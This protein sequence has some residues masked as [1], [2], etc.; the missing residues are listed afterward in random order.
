MS[1]VTQ[2]IR[3]ICNVSVSSETLTE[4]G[5]GLG[6]AQRFPSSRVY[7]NDKLLRTFQMAKWNN[8]PDSKTFVDLPL[9]EDPE[10]VV[11]R[12]KKLG[13]NPSELQAKSFLKQ[14]FYS[15]PRD[16]KQIA[17]YTPRDYKHDPPLFATRAF[18]K[19]HNLVLFAHAIKKRWPKLCREFIGINGSNSPQAPWQS[20]PRSSLIALPHPF[21]VPGGRFREMYYWDTLWIVQGL[22]ASQMLL[23]AMGVA[24]NCM[25]L[26]K[27][28]GFV[29]NGN[30][31]YYLNRSQ[32]PI[33]ASAV[34]EI[35]NALETKG[36]KILWA[37]ESLPA[38]ELEIESF[39]LH[40]SAGNEYKPLCRYSVSTE[41]PRP[42]S[43]RE[44][45]HTAERTKALRPRSKRSLVYKEIASAAESGWDFTSRFFRDYSE[46]L[47][48]VRT[49]KIIPVCLNSLL[50][51]SEQII[52]QM[53]EYLRDHLDVAENSDYYI[54]QAKMFAFKSKK[55][56]QMMN[57]VLWNDLHSTWMDY[58]MELEKHTETISIAGIMPLMGKC[59]DAWDD[60]MAENY[61]SALMKDSGLVLPGGLAA[62]A[63]KNSIEQWDHPNMWMP[64]VEMAV[65]GLRKL[66][67]AFPDSGAKEASEEIAIRSVRSVYRGWVSK[68]ELHEK[69]NAKSEDGTFGAGGEYLP[70]VGFAWT[71]GATLKLMSLYSKEMS[72]VSKASWF[73]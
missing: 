34:Y 29:P 60:N 23:T 11:R 3:K 2:W 28:L 12:F 71:N 9:R 17:F 66:G 26:V 68:R 69:Y 4:D 38:L 30:R 10:K 13:K 1:N 22:V 64:L 63:T 6:S 47:S 40:R 51:K 8:N 36:E 70:Q 61:V 73:D 48:S 39:S 72:H 54:D 31:V 7:C 33:L 42:E 19:G 37:L 5:L 18:P 14:N 41:K 46:G 35:F 55:R 25:Y 44:D 16:D 21:I 24:R 67:N 57:K 56:I 20:S 58:D 43:Y 52:S 15:S 62:T 59:G 45:V 27:E 50:L 49:S 65:E 53:Y 32:P